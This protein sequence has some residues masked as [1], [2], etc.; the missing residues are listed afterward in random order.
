MNPRAMNIWGYLRI[1]CTC[2]GRPDLTA[3]VDA[4]DLEA[5]ER[6]FPL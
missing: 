6:Q 3:M 4:K 2:L 5:L 1:S